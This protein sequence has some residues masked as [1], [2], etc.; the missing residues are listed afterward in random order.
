[1]SREK[2]TE[3][4]GFHEWGDSGQVD[5]AWIVRNTRSGE[6]VSGS[7]QFIGVFWL[8]FGGRWGTW[9]IGANNLRW[10]SL[11]GRASG[12]SELRVEVCSLIII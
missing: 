4:W 1:M 5:Y 6:I 7:I 12:L 11:R 3:G 2:A 8:R 9:G 10:R